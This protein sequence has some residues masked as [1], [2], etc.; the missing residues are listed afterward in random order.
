MI[1]NA[2]DMDEVV[3]EQFSAKIKLKNRKSTN[4]LDRLCFLHQILANK[5]TIAQQSDMFFHKVPFNSYTVW[6]STS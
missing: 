6:A 3:F 1:E 5:E 4:L 2:L